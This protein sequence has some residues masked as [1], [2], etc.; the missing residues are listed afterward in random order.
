MVEIIVDNY[1][2]K[3]YTLECDKTNTTQMYTKITKQIFTN[4]FK[5]KP[6]TSE[7]EHI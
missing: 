4:Y 2:S 7:T 1:K 6:L 5:K 3:Y